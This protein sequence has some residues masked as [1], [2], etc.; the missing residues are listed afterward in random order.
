MTGTADV[1]LA[2]ALAECR[3]HATTLGHALDDPA[4][5]AAFLN[6]LLAATEELLRFERRARDFAE[7]LAT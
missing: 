1:K 2:A 6:R 5:Q 4:I 7:R 3:L